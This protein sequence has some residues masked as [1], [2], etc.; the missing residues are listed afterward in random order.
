MKETELDQIA[1][2]YQQVFESDAGKKV[3]AD[4]EIFCNQTRSS[5][6]EQ[7]P[8]ALQT[9]F[10]EGKRRVFLRILWQLKRKVRDE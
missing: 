10:E 3:L 9:F 2:D 6:C 4:L 1:R 5:V 8:N 7:N